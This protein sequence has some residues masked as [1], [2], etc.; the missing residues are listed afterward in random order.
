M[1]A[2][3]IAWIGVAVAFLVADGLWLGLVMKSYYTRHLQP[4]R[5]DSYKLGPAILFYIA[6]TLSITVLAIA[7]D[8]GVVDVGTAA[9][10][11]AVIGFA[12]YGAYNMTNYCTLAN[13]P[14]KVSM[15][16]WPW[17]TFATAVASAF[18]AISYNFWS[19][20]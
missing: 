19:G 17:G 15:V 1:S 5:R 14:L 4:I 3:L 2:W 7:P 9:F 6:Y 12:S 10:T 20:I 18:G 11:G 8:A 16:D 13:W